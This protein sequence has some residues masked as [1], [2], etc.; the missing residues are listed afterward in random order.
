LTCCLR[1]L[2]AKVRKKCC[3]IVWL[4]CFGNQG[5]EFVLF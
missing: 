5:V 3:V 2:Q 1:G 4:R